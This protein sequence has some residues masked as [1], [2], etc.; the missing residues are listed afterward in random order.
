MGIHETET[1]IAY[2]HLDG[3]A[4]TQDVCQKLSEEQF[5]VQGKTVKLPVKVNKAAN[6]FATF[7]V[8][9][10][11]A[12]N[13]IAASGF[14]IAEIFPGKAIMQLLAV[15]YMEND[16]GDYNE[17]GI[18]FYVRQPGAPKGLPVLSTIRDIIKGSAASY[19]HVLP[20]DQEFT[21]H[22]GRYI[23]GYPKWI[24]DIDIAI[25]DKEFVTRLSDQGKHIFTL[26]CKMGGRSKMTNQRQ[27]SLAVRRGIAYRTEGIANGSG[28]TF[29]MG[30]EAP[31]LG[32]HPI[33]D[34][35]RKL[36][37]PKKPLFSGSVA[38][39]TMDFGPAVSR[40]VGVAIPC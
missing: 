8:D 2:D 31:E 38:N 9:A 11:A 24:A 3:G 25:D 34:E 14:E 33:A 5:L 13:W 21:M 30:G 36:G 18:S 20:V 39:M 32:D 7:L 22:A 29:R 6:A 26:R 16:L 27:P 19:I 35:L 15:D 4:D 28:V 37:L 40:P 12:Q 17:A 23:W 1:T 10:R